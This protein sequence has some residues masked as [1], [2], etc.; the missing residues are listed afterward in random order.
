MLVQAVV[1]FPEQAH[2]IG[3]FGEFR[4]VLGMRMRFGQRE[5]AEHETQVVAHRFLHRFQLGISLAA[6][7]T[8]E[9]AVLHEHQAC[10]EWALG[11]I[12]WADIGFEPAHGCAPAAG[13]SFSN[14]SRMPSAPGLMPTGDTCVQRTMPSLSMTNSARWLTPS[15]NW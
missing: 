7:R 10:I 3:R 8:F 13:G 5:V 4:C 6:I 11:M 12:G 2:G 14:A 1:H 15:G 9:I